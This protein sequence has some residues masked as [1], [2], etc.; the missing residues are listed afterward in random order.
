MSDLDPNRIVVQEEIDDF[1]D[2]QQI[3]MSEYK[4]EVEAQESS[5]LFNMPALTNQPLYPEEEEPKIIESDDSVKSEVSKTIQFVHP[6][7]VSSSSS[8]SD[9]TETQIKGTKRLKWT[10]NSGL[11]DTDDLSSDLSDF[12]SSSESQD[13]EEDVTALNIKQKEQL[14]DMPKK[15]IRTEDNKVF[16]KTILSMISSRAKKFEEK[17]L[18]T[19][20]N[21]ET[22]AAYYTQLAEEM[23]QKITKYLTEHKKAKIGDIVNYKPTYKDSIMWTDVYRVRDYNITLEEKQKF[24]KTIENLE[25]LA[26]KLMIVKKYDARSIALGLGVTLVESEISVDTIYDI[27]D[28]CFDKRSSKTRDIVMKGIVIGYSKLN[29]RIEYR[30]SINDELG[31]LQVEDT[32]NPKF[33]LGDERYMANMAIHHT[34][35]S[36]INMHDTVSSCLNLIKKNAKI[37][38]FDTPNMN[39]HMNMSIEEINKM[40]EIFNTIG[41]TTLNVIDQTENIMDNV[42]LNIVIDNDEHDDIVTLLYSMAYDAVII[43]N[44]RHKEFD[45]TLKCCEKHRKIMMRKNE[46]CPNKDDSCCIRM[47]KINDTRY[48]SIKSFV[49]QP[50]S[51]K[52]IFHTPV[53]RR[54]TTRVRGSETCTITKNFL[55]ENKLIDCAGSTLKSNNKW[56]MQIINENSLINYSVTSLAM[57]DANI[58]ITDYGKYTSI[59][60]VFAYLDPSQINHIVSKEMMTIDVDKANQ[61]KIIY[62]GTDQDKVLDTFDI[63]TSLRHKTMT[64]IVSNVFNTTKTI[65]DAP[66]N[67]TLLTRID[68]F[69]DHINYVSH[70]I[71]SKVMLQHSLSVIKS[72]EKL[73]ICKLTE[74]AKQHILMENMEIA[75]QKCEVKDELYQKTILDNKMISV[76]LKDTIVVPKK[77]TKER[78]EE[79]K[80]VFNNMILGP[81]LYRQLANIDDETQNVKIDLTDNYM[82]SQM[83]VE[84][85]LVRTKLVNVEYLNTVK[86]KMYFDMCTEGKEDFMKVKLINYSNTRK[87]FKTMTKKEIIEHKNSISITKDLTDEYDDEIPELTPQVKNK[88]RFNDMFRKRMSS[89]QYAK[90]HRDALSS[91][92]YENFVPKEN[93]YEDSTLYDEIPVITYNQSADSVSTLVKGMHNDDAKKLIES[94]EKHGNKIVKN[95]MTDMINSLQTL[96]S[97]YAPPCLPPFIW[98]YIDPSIKMQNRRMRMVALMKVTTADYSIDVWYW[99]YTKCVVTIKFKPGYWTLYP[100]IA[101]LHGNS[102]KNLPTS[103]AEMKMEIDVQFSVMKN[104]KPVMAY[105]DLFFDYFKVYSIPMR[106]IGLT[107]YNELLKYYPI[108]V[109]NVIERFEESDT[110]GWGEYLEARKAPMFPDALIMMDDT[111]ERFYAQAIIRI[112]KDG[113]IDVGTELH[114]IIDTLLLCQNILMMPNVVV[115]YLSML[116]PLYQW[117]HIVMHMRTCY[118]ADIPENA[119]WQDVIDEFMI[120]PG[121]ECDKCKCPHFTNDIMYQDICAVK[122]A[123]SA[124]KVTTSSSVLHI[125]SKDN[126]Q[127]TR[128]KQ[129][130]DTWISCDMPIRGKFTLLMLKIGARKQRYQRYYIVNSL[131]KARRDLFITQWEPKIGRNTDICTLISEHIY[132]SFNKKRSLIIIGSDELGSVI[133]KYDDSIRITNRNANHLYIPD[134]LLFNAI[135]SKIELVD[136]DEIDENEIKVINFAKGPKQRKINKKMRDVVDVTEENYIVDSV[137]KIYKSISA[138]IRNFNFKQDG[139]NAIMI[140]MA[141]VILSLIF[142]IHYNII[143]MLISIMYK[144]VLIK[145]PE[146]IVKKV[147]MIIFKSIVIGS[148]TILTTALIII[149]AIVCSVYVREKDQD[150]N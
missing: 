91:S 29:K 148:G 92:F 52:I 113:K 119:E 143:K 106:L 134:T 97:G 73:F 69:K 147:L 128:Y 117:E 124:H 100:A 61:F 101:L 146:Y 142:P 111:Q 139:S 60:Q 107:P 74:E 94:F 85:Q 48:M 41:I 37:I 138:K 99:I 59:S 70:I 32:T 90:A 121:M 2:K 72:R 86:S 136:E 120:N 76:N 31:L 46:V 3:T 14:K 57:A 63:V 125:E 145:M 54:K 82:I 65:I 22:L 103:N 5:M 4:K 66:Y 64:K 55:K 43:T 141:L 88:I 126:F 8:S 35:S 81:P 40:S 10:K 24:G 83:N 131:I 98:S 16:T 1:V 39:R 27:I 58:T 122:N 108:I 133:K 21:L 84:P 17:H 45:I 36:K 123:P 42:T 114:R 19:P 62:P 144:I 51:Y 67:S 75:M 28:K 149:S 130:K 25:T 20:P 47:I 23:K 68:K 150:E 93:I 110:G 44:D 7:D 49:T 105:Q 129:F 78:I 56:T 109:D 102:F 26:T 50:N 104:I 135:R 38:I 87:M 137:K 13:K 33:K 9:T 71:T 15:I 18:I 112:M 96:M 89:N 12:S 79:N 53:I 115:K 95:I 140:V 118:D 6:D 116:R 77:G 30:T 80:N 127:I 11:T 34:V 132:R